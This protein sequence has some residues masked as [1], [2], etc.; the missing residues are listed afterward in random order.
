[1]MVYKMWK[2]T[3]VLYAYIAAGRIMII[4]DPYVLIYL[5]ELN[6]YL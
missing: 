6:I 3:I 1:M 4:R 2:N 5:I